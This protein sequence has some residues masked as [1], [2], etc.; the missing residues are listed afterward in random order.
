L[1]GVMI[2]VSGVYFVSFS[3]P[4]GNTSRSAAWRDS[5]YGLAVAICFSISPIFIR[6][7]LDDLPSPLLGVTIGM[8]ISAIAY[9][10]LILIRREPVSDRTPTLD[11]IL[12]QIAAGILV[13]LSTWMRW[14]ALDTAPVAV[15]LALGRLN[16]PVV[17]LVS[18]VLI[19]QETERVTFKVV[20]GAALIVVGSLILIFF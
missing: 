11:S 15:V 18:L 3:R 5:I 14:I 6:A 2:V 16:V 20:L 1:A 12:F 10:I 8:I 4:N 19:G 9:G 13:G 7:G 17:I